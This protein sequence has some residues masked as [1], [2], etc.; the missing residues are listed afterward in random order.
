[1][2]RPK[3]KTFTLYLKMDITTIV[4]ALKNHTHDA[5]LRVAWPDRPPPTDRLDDADWN[6]LR[7]QCELPA[8]SGGIDVRALI[9]HEIANFRLALRRE[10]T[11]APIK[12]K[13]AQLL[14]IVK[15]NTGDALPCK[16]HDEVIGLLA[17]MAWRDRR[18]GNSDWSAFAR[19]RHHVVLQDKVTPQLQEW[20]GMCLMLGAGHR[21]HDRNRGG[22]HSF[23]TEVFISV[24]INC[25]TDVIQREATTW[26][27]GSRGAVS[28]ARLTRFVRTCLDQA[29]VRAWTAPPTK[30][31]RMGPPPVGPRRRKLSL[32][33]VHQRILRV[34]RE[35]RAAAT[36]GLH[37]NVLS[38]MLND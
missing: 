28:A 10:E 9:E 22:G 1:M 38:R 26:V 18:F 3:A 4:Q 23:A 19:W 5:T 36:A 35:M 8:N 7:R 14:A 24:L 31:I 33:D 17:G 15:A 2:P 16:L 29:G 32:G 37:P 25:W 13:H 20:A 34:R 12:A 27:G 21:S 6:R 30:R 11:L